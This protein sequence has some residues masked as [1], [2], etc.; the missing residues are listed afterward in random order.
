M[1]LFTFSLSALAADPLNTWTLRSPLP[2]PNPLRDIIYT[3]GLWV[4]V[5]D[6][7]TVITSSDDGQTWARQSSGLTNNDNRILG[8]T[9]GA[10]KFAV[11]TSYGESGTSTNGTNWNFQTMGI[12]NGYANAI[13]YGNGKFVAGG[14]SATNLAVSTNGIN[15]LPIVAVVSGQIKDVTYAQG[16]FVAVGTGVGLSGGFVLSSA[17][18]TNWTT[19]VTGFSGGLNGITFG[20]GKFVGVGY[21]G[22]AISTDGTNWAQIYNASIPARFSVAYGNGQFVAVGAAGTF[23]D[24]GVSYS[25]TNGTNWVSG[26]GNQPSAEVV[27][28]AN[29]RFASVG[30]PSLLDVGTPNRVSFCTNVSNWSS[31][32]FGGAFSSSA[33]DRRSLAYGNGQ[34]AAIENSSSIVL[35]TNGSNYTM[36]AVAANMRALAYGTGRFVAARADSPSTTVFHASDFSWNQVGG[37]ILGSV[38]AMIATSS[39]WVAVGQDGLVA[40]SPD[41]LLWASS[42]SATTNHLLAISY[43]AGAF[44]GVGVAGT[45]V[46]STDGVNWTA[47]TVSGAGELRSVTF[48]RSTFVAVGFGGKIFTSPNGTTWTARSSGT[49]LSLNSVS[50]CL[51]RFVAVGDGGITLSSADGVAWTRATPLQDDNLQSVAAAPTLALAVGDASG[52][53]TSTNAQNW[54]WSPGSALV[55][56]LRRIIYSNGRFIAAA[57]NGVAYSTSGISWRSQLLT[58][59]YSLVGVNG[60]IVAVGSGDFSSQ[61]TIYISSDNGTTW[62]RT[63]LGSSGYLDGIA[64]GNGTYVA[65]GQSGLVYTSPDA[66]NWTSRTSGTSTT[67]FDV[68]FGNNTFVA[69]LDGSTNVLTSSDGINWTL[70]PTVPGGG[71]DAV[72]FRDGLFYGAVSRYMTSPDGI[73]WT[74]RGAP[75]SPLVGMEK[76]YNRYIAYG[77][78]GVLLTSSNLTTW[79]TVPTLT[80]QEFASAA[81]GNDTFLVVGRGGIIFQSDFLTNTPVSITSA[82]S[83]TTVLSGGVATFRV[84]AAG[85][86]PFSYQ[87]F[88]NGSLISGAVS[89]SLTLSNVT[90][91][92]AG[93]YHAVVNGDTS[94]AT[95]SAA[96]LTV[97]TV[98]AAVQP[99]TLYAFTNTSAT[100]TAVVTGATPTAYQWFQYFNTPIPGATN[101]TLTLTNVQ[102]SDATSYKFTATLALG[103]TTSTN[104]GSLTVLDT[105][106]DVNL[107]VEPSYTLI[108]SGNS[109]SLEALVLGPVPNSYQWFKNGGLI[110]EATNAVLPIVNAQTN[111]SG[112]YTYFVT[113]PQGNVT[114]EF[115]PGTLEVYFATPPILSGGRFLNPSSFQLTFTGLTNRSYAIETATNLNPPVVWE[116][117]DTKTVTTNP[118]KFPINTFFLPNANAHYFRVQILPPF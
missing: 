29:G 110:P 38:N 33:S 109:I 44:V 7:G 21:S 78:N 42:S 48:A 19:R 92:D 6:A 55:T 93:S 71:C 28:F 24:L 87:W 68:A 37:G 40:T 102:A 41:G 74:D 16:L 61:T 43:G 118:V 111:N 73:T 3:N 57:D 96:T 95:S 20:N 47:V 49:L 31:P 82:P 112:D 58:T 53:Q 63:N 106:N 99:E 97:V 39:L 60:L 83:N 36:V 18:G 89:A 70:R 46:R 79:S 51:G 88:K 107:Y 84:G 12:L 77:Y 45:T 2:T 98:S 4:A 117:F 8:L 80:S 69:S 100:F 50:D 94:S 108:P 72:V 81:G 27:R 66:V 115:N 113:Y 26:G 10:G 14:V 22:T 65:V 67:L 116:Y 62:S 11:V 9:Y 91:A 17:D 34:F 30:S 59:L 101:A 25:S 5:G 35:T 23:L 90:S 56:N 32:G 114:N 64:Y 104:E 76:A 105:L 85:R 15:W 13:T 103:Q 75:P 86:G 1:A 54:Q 52:S